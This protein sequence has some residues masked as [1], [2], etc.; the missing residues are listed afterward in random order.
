MC[1]RWLHNKWGA[2]RVNGVPSGVIS[3]IVTKVRQVFQRIECAAL[4]RE[5][6][7]R[8]EFFV[9]SVCST[10]LA[11]AQKNTVVF[12]RSYFDFVRLRNYLKAEKVP[13]SSQLLCL[14]VMPYPLFHSGFLCI[15]VRVLQIIRRGAV[16]RALFSRRAC[17]HAGDGALLV[18]QASA[19]SW[20]HACHILQSA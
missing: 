9:R 8:F 18:L 11:S 7:E 4:E 10:V 6:T 14:L 13:V 5:P 1:S 15:S 3:S 2:L 19:A 12:I 20:R 17:A 16:S